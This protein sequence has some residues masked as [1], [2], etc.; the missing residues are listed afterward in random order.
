MPLQPTL[1][2]RTCSILCA[3]PSHVLPS[4][5]HCI[6]GLGDDFLTLAI[7]FVGL[8]HTSPT[9]SSTACAPCGFSNPSQILPPSPGLPL[10]SPSRLLAL[11]P[12]LP[13]PLLTSCVRLRRRGSSCMR[14]RTT[15]ARSAKPGYATH[16]R[17]G[18]PLPACSKLPAT[19]VTAEGAYQV[20]DMS[21]AVADVRP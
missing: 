18:M 8:G 7:Y 21:C 4:V 10:P 17:T 20:K 12:L 15:C 1:P 16:T 13:R 14:P 6:P 11:P 9:A 2:A 3:V 5:L 19:A